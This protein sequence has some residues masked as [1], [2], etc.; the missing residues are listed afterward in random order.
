[1]SFAGE[2]MQISGQV[3]SLFFMGVS[4]SGMLLPWL[5]GQF[6]ESAGPYSVMVI[7]FLAILLS[8]IFF[9]LADRLSSR[10]CP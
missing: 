5:I 4:A 3:T 7:L 8:L 2:R 1:M 10:R 9:A 6:F